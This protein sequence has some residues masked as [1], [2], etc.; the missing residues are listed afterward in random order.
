M[1]DLDAVARA[2]T[3]SAPSAESKCQ[4]YPLLSCFALV[5]WQL[6]TI[7]LLQNWSLSCATVM[8]PAQHVYS[9]KMQVEPG[10]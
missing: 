6:K 7:E 10:C 1:F 9:L 5:G 8:L 3:F 2:A 4:L